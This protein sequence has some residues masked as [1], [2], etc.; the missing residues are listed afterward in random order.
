MHKEPLRSFT[1]RLASLRVSLKRL[2]CGTVLIGGHSVLGGLMKEPFFPLAPREQQIAE[3]LLQGCENDEIGKRLNIARRTVKA[4]FNRL[5][6]RFGITTGIKRVKLATL[7]YRRQLCLE[8]SVTE[9]EFQAP[10]NIELLSS[11]PKVSRTGTLQTQSE[12]LNMSS[13]TISEPSTTNS[14]SGTGSN[15]RSGTRLAGTKTYCTPE[16]LEKWERRILS[17]ERASIYDTDVN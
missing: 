9:N 15:S 14:D 10:G 6:V 5:F 7:L 16:V 13:K 12:P 1:L 4:H 11:W 8:A 17:L 2:L 3:L